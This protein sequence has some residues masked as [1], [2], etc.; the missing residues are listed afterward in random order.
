[1]Q[2]K[3]KLPATGVKGSPPASATLLPPLP[4]VPPVYPLTQTSLEMHSVSLS[5]P[6]APFHHL[7]LDSNV[8]S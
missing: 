4:P 6:M 2:V 5:S 3:S 7:G 1:M 8:I